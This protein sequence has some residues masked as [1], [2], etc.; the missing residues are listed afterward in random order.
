MD[1]MGAIIILLLLGLVGWLVSPP[2]GALRD[3]R[4]PAGDRGSDNPPSR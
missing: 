1:W 4:L 3:A 2:L